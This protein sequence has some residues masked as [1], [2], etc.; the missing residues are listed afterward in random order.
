METDRRNFIKLLAAMG[1]YLHAGK[2][3]LSAA[4]NLSGPRDPERTGFLDPDEK[5]GFWKLFRFIGKVWKNEEY[6]Q[7]SRG[8]FEEITDLKTGKYPSYLN[9]YRAAL[10]T[11]Q[12]LKDRYSEGE[13]LRRLF[14][15]EPDPGLR[16]C[17]I[18]ELI[19]LQM[20]HG[21]FRFLGYANYKGYMGGSFGIP[22]SL[23]YRGMGA[24]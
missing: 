13:A 7:L 12:K 1:F 22:G 2:L 6:C 18:A 5:T 8:G 19:E 9:E 15:E 11:F 10:A 14:F 16:G 20:A 17:V 23:P 3:R 4:T 24:G 21:G